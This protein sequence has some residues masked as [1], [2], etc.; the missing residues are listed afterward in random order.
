[1]NPYIDHPELA[2]FVWG[3]YTSEAWSV[4]GTLPEAEIALEVY[5]SVSTSLLH[6]KINKPAETTYYIQ[7]LSGIALKTGKLSAQGTLPISE[8]SSGMYILVA[9]SGTTRKVGKFIVQRN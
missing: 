8:L 4:D 6:V 3:K 9:Y 7:S 5:Y 1:R 2:E